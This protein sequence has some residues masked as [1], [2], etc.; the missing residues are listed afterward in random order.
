MSKKECVFDLSLSKFT[1]INS[2]TGKTPI[3]LLFFVLNFSCFYVSNSCSISRLFNFS[4]YWFCLFRPNISD[5][6]I[7]FNT[8]WLTV[9]YSSVLKIS[10][11][12]LSWD[13]IEVICLVDELFYY[14]LIISGIVFS[15]ISSG[16]G[17]NLELTFKSS[18][19]ILLN[20]V[21]LL[22]CVSFFD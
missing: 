8:S 11:L 20:R 12:F 13:C 18:S 19:L 17:R 6:F 2:F 7:Y 10:K 15:F 9:V 21:G 4:F 14:L 22:M 16:S 1:G 5:S 3:L